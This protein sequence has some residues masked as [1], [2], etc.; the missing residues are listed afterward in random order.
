MRRAPWIIALAISA[1]LASAG[2]NWPQFRGPQGNG[3]ADSTG[4]PLAWS[5]A[6]NVA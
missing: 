4:L 3:H 2:E 6:E 1:S 5:E